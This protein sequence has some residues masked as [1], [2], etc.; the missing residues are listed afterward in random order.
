MK[1]T[2]CSR[3]LCAALLLAFAG[4]ARAAAP[5]YIGPNAG[6]WSAPTSWS[7]AAVPV[8]GDDVTVGNNTA[9]AVTSAVF[10]TVYGGAGMNS[11]VINAATAS[12]FTVTQSGAGTAMIAQTLTLGTTT[13]GAVYDQTNGTASFTTANIGTSPNGQ[14]AYLLGGSGAATFGTLNVGLSAMAVNGGN[15]VTQTGGTSTVN[16][17]LNIAT[18]LTTSGA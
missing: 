6:L 13:F 1:T 7:T 9:A 5:G 14:G 3:P 11:L 18:G 12:T 4:G 17:A 8:I 2:S 16:T 15:R 10:N